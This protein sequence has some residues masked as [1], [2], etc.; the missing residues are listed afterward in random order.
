MKRAPIGDPKRAIAYVRASTTDQKLTHEA[1]KTAIERW[2]AREGV[3]LVELFAE[4]KS[5]A[6][7]IEQRSIIDAIAACREHHAGVLVVVQRDRIARDV[8]N[9]ILL[10]RLA[11]KNGAKIL[12]LAGEGTGDGDPVTE[13]AFRRMIDTFA[14]ME[15]GMIGT[16]TR[17]VLARRR[18]QGLSTGAVPF[19]FRNDGGRL[20]RDERESKIVAQIVRW[21]RYG[22]TYQKI[23]DEL[24]RRELKNR[25]GNPILYHQVARIIWRHQRQQQEKSK[26]TDRAA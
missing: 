4:H 12:S 14:E 1:Q 10:E 17:A 5:G 25:A 24:G 3:E 22:W 15:R 7:K 21:R 9:A 13:R 11:E 8:F 26:T 6:K 23:T 18:E 20:V 16:R 19:G 2:C